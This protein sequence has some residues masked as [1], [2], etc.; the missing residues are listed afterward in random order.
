MF[1]RRR[2][3]EY[4]ST[5]SPSES[6]SEP[7]LEFGRYKDGDAVGE[8]KLEKMLGVGR[9][10][11]VF[12]AKDSRGAAVA[13]KA[14]RHSSEAVDSMV[15]EAMVLRAL[16]GSPHVL[17]IIETIVDSY[18]NTLL[19]LDYVD[20]GDT[21]SLLKEMRDGNLYFSDAQIRTFSA[22][23][24]EA[25]AWIHSKAFTS[26]DIKPGNI[27]INKEHT[28]V[29]MCDLGHATKMTKPYYDTCLLYTS[30]SPRDRTRSRMPS[31][32]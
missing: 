12:L 23:L 2:P 9:F 15:D 20:G 6:A 1:T 24:I 26:S 14:P 31:S 11:V 22:Q 10:G 7:P 32:A 28:K 19:V 21:E 8:Y 25:L 13:V 30:P 3:Y 16:S 5:P 18:A 4:G 27:L 17:S 29:K